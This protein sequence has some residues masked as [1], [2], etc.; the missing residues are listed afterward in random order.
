MTGPKASDGTMSES[1]TDHLPIVDEFLHYLL[2][3]RHFSP[4]TARCYGVDL[5]QYVEYLS[6]DRNI[7][8]DR[9]REGVR[10]GVAITRLLPERAHTPAPGR[11]APR[12]SGE[13]SAE[14]PDAGCAG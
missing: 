14:G 2:D 7:Q 11:T 10:V 1:R 4:Y 13:R 5:R 6:D 12:G 8:V 3:E 9:G